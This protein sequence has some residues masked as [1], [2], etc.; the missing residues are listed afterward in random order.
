MR[1]LL[2]LLF[3]FR[4]FVLFLVLEALCLWMIISYN[5]TQSENFHLYVSNVNARI[6]RV[7]SN[8]RAYFNLRKE[9][10]KLVLENLNLKN[11]LRKFLSQKF[12]Y[13]DSVNFLSSSVSDSAML[14]SLLL[15]WKFISARVVNNGIIHPYNFLTLDAGRR[16]GIKRGMGVLCNEGVVGVIVSASENFSVAASI[17]NLN[18]KISA[19]LSD[20][21][22]FGTLEWDGRSSRFTKLNYIPSQVPIRKG[23]KILTSDFSSMFPPDI[24][25]GKVENFNLPEGIN[26]Y[27]ITVRLSAPMHRLSEVYVA[28]NVMMEEKNKL[29]SETAKP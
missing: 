6:F 14:D 5:K 20:D 10:Q 8:I 24:S 4:N 22:S 16:Q 7:Q 3:R 11:E 15:K 23:E 25:I 21:G 18:T 27:D 17:L 28:G 12:V 13:R 26:F 29:E 1:G 2:L 9:N 19:K